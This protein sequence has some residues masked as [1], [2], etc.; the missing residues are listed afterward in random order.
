MTPMRRNVMSLEQESSDSPSGRMGSSRSATAPF[1]FPTS[2]QMGDLV[3]CL[4][5]RVSR[6][7]FGPCERGLP[8]AS[9]HYRLAM[10]TLAQNSQPQARG[11]HFYGLPGLGNGHVGYR[12]L[13][14]VNPA[15]Y[16][17]GHHPRFGYELVC[18]PDLQ[19]LPVQEGLST[20][21]QQG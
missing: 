2:N 8:L 19:H 10:L 1:W 11:H 7:S 15:H 12:T 5:S 16:C 3:F 18:I 9:H 4:A 6:P 14:R 20:N 21:N 13:E 17:R